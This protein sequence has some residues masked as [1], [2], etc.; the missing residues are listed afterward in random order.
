MITEQPD[1]EKPWGLGCIIC[2]RYSAWL[3][4]DKAAE[5]AASPSDEAG[6]SA[7]TTFSVGS[8]SAKSLGIEDCLRHLGR[9][10]WAKPSGRFHAK[11]M[12]HFK[13]T[14]AADPGTEPLV[15]PAVGLGDRDDVP[16]LSQIRICYD[17]VTRAPPLGKTCEV[18]CTR[19]REAGDATAAAWQGEKHASPKIARRIAAALFEQDRQLRS[20]GKIAAVG[21]AQDSRKKVL[22]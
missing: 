16:T 14:R 8:R 15:Q 13:S 21:I 18:E 1:Q 19:A 22:S 4:T 12:G 5:G 10:S 11:A 17:I 2:S 3:K 20:Q 7:W 9:A 6:A